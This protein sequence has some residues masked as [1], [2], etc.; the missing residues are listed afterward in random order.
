VLQTA[1]HGFF[2]GLPAGCLVAAGVTLVGCV[3]AAILL[4]ARPKP[5]ASE[6]VTEPESTPEPVGASR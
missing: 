3:F 4:P 1:N 5:A 2:D 6:D